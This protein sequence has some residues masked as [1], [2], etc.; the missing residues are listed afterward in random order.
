M[1]SQIDVF[2]DPFPDRHQ[3]TLGMMWRCRDSTTPSH[4]SRRF[5]S[6]RDT[7]EW[8]LRFRQNVHSDIAL[9]CLSRKIDRLDGREHVSHRRPLRTCGEFGG[10]KSNMEMLT[11]RP[12]AACVASG[13]TSPSN[14][15]HGHCTRPLIVHSGVRSGK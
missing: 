12:F 6:P 8:S 7:K 3:L 9:Q 4:Y 10:A 5:W 13:V 14:E 15:G 11:R 2:A 1:T